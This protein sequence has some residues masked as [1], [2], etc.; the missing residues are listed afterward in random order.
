MTEEGKTNIG[1]RGGAVLVFVG[2][3]QQGLVLL[4]GVR[5][6]KRAERGS[7]A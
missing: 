4:G 3:L 7:E 2:L 1:S 6:E 5:Y